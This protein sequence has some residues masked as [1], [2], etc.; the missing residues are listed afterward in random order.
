M[1]DFRKT[2]HVEDFTSP[3]GSNPNTR[4]KVEKTRARRLQG[5]ETKTKA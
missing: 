5:K 4:E 1:P 2:P 3:V